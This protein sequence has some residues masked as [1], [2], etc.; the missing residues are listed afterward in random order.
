VRSARICTFNFLSPDVKVFSNS[1]SSPQAGED[2]PIQT[3]LPSQ[4]RIKVRGNFPLLQL[5]PPGEESIGGPGRGR[6]EM[7]SYPGTHEEGTTY[8]IE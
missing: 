1:V 3:P 5:L 7:T 4:E 8:D 6:V 2:F